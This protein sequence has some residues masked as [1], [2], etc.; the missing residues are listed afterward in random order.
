MWESQ[1]AG[2]PTEE[3]VEKLIEQYGGIRFTL[4]VQMMLILALCSR[5]WWFYQIPYYIQ[6]PVY[7]CTWTGG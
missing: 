5:C 6:E 2:E 3:K 4:F 1:I 7:D